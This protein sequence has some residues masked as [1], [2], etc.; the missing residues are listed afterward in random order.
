MD[1][2]SH[3][4]IYHIMLYFPPKLC[5]MFHWD[6][7]MCWNLCYKKSFRPGIS[8][9]PAEILPWCRT[10]FKCLIVFCCWKWSFL[11]I[12]FVSVLLSSWGKDKNNLYLQG[13]QRGVQNKIVQFA[14]IQR[15]GGFELAECRSLKALLLGSIVA[16]GT[17]LKFISSLIKVK[18]YLLVK[19][20]IIRTTSNPTTYLKTVEKNLFCKEK[21][22]WNMH[23][24]ACCL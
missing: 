5:S 9:S 21:N 20:F 16:A 6:S 22:I 10:Y 11:L 3:S 2:I 4:P 12:W 14:S 19:L 23:R 15:Q 8:E 13:Q 17:N 7:F 24:P 18:D 1:F